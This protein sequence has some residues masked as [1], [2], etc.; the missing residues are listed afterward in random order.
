MNI[1]KDIISSYIQCLNMNRKNVKKNRKLEEDGK[2]EEGTTKERI[3]NQETDEYAKEKK[4]KKGKKK[5][6]ETVN[7]ILISE[8]QNEK[9]CLDGERKDGRGT[10]GQTKRNP[11][12]VLD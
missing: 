8:Y 12:I 10:G 9:D 7:T 3:S 6:C 4:N 11:S 2:I 5:K 1:S